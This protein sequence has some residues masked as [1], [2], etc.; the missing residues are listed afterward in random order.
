MHKFFATALCFAL[1]GCTTQS[2]SPAGLVISDVTIVSPERA[3]PL[4]HAYVRVLDGKIVEVSTRPRAASK[5]SM[6]PAAISFPDSSTVTCIL[7]CLPAF[8]RR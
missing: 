3:T 7:L 8:L 6:V 2:Q 1:I 5:R 4:E